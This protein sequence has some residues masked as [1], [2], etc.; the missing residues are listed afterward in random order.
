MF[1]VDK[2]VVLLG[3]GQNLNKKQAVRKKRI[4]NTDQNLTVSVTRALRR[5]S[6]RGF[7]LV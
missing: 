3:A 5:V 2:S 7:A 4:V 6:F 1:G